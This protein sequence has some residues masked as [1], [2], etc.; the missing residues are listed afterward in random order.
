MLNPFLPSLLL[1]SLS[2]A[3][4]SSY[5]SSSTTTTTTAT[6]IS[7]TTPQSNNN[8]HP[9]RVAPVGPLQPWQ[10][11]ALVTHTPSGY[12]ASHPYARL[13]VSI[14]DPNTIVLGKTQFGDAAFP[15]TNTSCSVSWLPYDEK[16]YPRGRVNPCDEIASGKWT[17]QILNGTSTVNGIPGGS[18][19][20]DF[21]LRFGL[22]EA[23]VLASGCVVSL[24]WR[25]EAAFKIGVNMDGACGASGA[26]SWGLE[27][28]LVP[29]LVNQTLVERTVVAGQCDG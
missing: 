18:P 8:T 4:V 23:V 16:E 22:A 26:C 3:R 17:V 9:P 13:F 6:T 19:T 5:S 10:I 29:V 21:V 25:G 20:G 15:P 1:T 2:V 14:G 7:T 24:R 11:T 27:D 28:R 12:P